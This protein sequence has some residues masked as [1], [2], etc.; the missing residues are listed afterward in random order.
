HAHF[1]TGVSD[2]ADSAFTSR[3][4]AFHKYVCSFQTGVKG[5]FSSIGSSQLGGIGRVLLGAL[6][7]HFTGRR[8]GDHL[9]LLVGN[10]YDD[11]VKTGGYV[12]IPVVI[13][14]YYPL[15]ISSSF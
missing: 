7:A 11:I 4:G 5:S 1:D 3:T 6:E 13:Y 10:A 9:T 12:H 15:F 2:G 8:P 14:L